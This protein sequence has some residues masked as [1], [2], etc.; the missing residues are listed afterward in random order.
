MAAYRLVRT[1]H[2]V[3][4]CARIAVLLGIAGSAQSALVTVD[5][6]AGGAGVLAL[7]TGEVQTTPGTNLLVNGQSLKAPARC[8]MQLDGPLT[9][10]RAEI[11]SKSGLFLGDYLP[12][13]AWIVLLQPEQLAVVKA[14][15]FVSW[16]GRF[17][18]DWKI[19]PEL[20]A[21][22]Y[23]SDA[24]RALQAQGLC[25]VVVVVFE[26]EGPD[27]VLAA[28]N[29]AGAQTLDANLC[30]PQWMIDAVL[31]PDA[32]R[33][34]ASLSSV[35]FIEDAPEGSLRNDSNRWILQSNVSGQT[36]VWARGIHGEGQIGGLIDDTP[37]ES[38]CMFD[39]SVAPG[40]VSHRKFVG[41]RNASGVAFHGTHTAGTMAGDNAPY[42]AYSNNDGI[43]YAAKL[44]FSN[45]NNV[46]QSPTTLQ[47]RLQ[48]AHNDG[49]RVHSNSWGDDGTTAYTTWCR[50]I[51]LF[52]W[53]NEDNLVVFAVS[54]LSSLKTPEN[55]INVLAVGATNDSPSQGN[56]C[57]G[58]AGPTAD[59]RRKPEIYAP[60]CGTQSAD[61]NSTCSVTSSSGTSMACP[62]ISGSGLLVRQY[63]TDG[64]YPSG[65]ATPGDAFTPS[66]ALIKAVLLNGSVDMTGVTGYPGN[67]EGWGRLL[68]DNALHFTGDLSK[69]RISDTRNADGLTTGQVV[70]QEIIC[71]SSGAPLRITL[72]WTG[73][74][75]SINAA[76]PVI[77]NLDLEVVAPGGVLYRGNVFSSGQS[78]TGGTAD[79][80][81]NVEQFLLSVPA[82]GAYTVRV[83]GTTVNQGPQ[84][85]ALAIT[86]DISDPC[87]APSILGQPD[88]VT[89]DEGA[90]AEFGV[91]ASGGDL[92]YIWR[93]NGFALSNDTRI[94]GANTATLVINPVTI[95]DAGDYD[96]IITGCDSVTSDPVAL[97]V[98][99]GNACP[100]D[101][102]GVEGLGVPD[103]FHFLSLWFANDPAADWDGENGL[104][105]PDIFTYLSDWF[106]GC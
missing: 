78:T 70:E 56:I 20:A 59:G 49:A 29:K 23:G 24:R 43:A 94:A 37:R 91:I 5:D 41:W 95:D 57:Y 45:L 68:L 85:Y 76:N 69:L 63:F 48:D 52:S 54:N 35:Q 61:S 4:V 67:R 36:P 92:S 8:V 75:A 74:A 96:V 80:K 16:I 72:V 105:V 17:E 42:G 103:I 81:N 15:P 25:Q 62:A 6:A 86:G 31:T 88:P 3:V 65:A 55:S 97:S 90:S 99:P 11:L 34:L 26:G 71:E 101:I 100:A 44:S 39:D 106:G 1:P 27:E 12:D 50:Q 98:T 13:N 82:T 73:P 14:I 89:A 53:E 21:R 83:R 32:A 28:L 38:H 51:D 30:G 66:G 60:G 9:A 40:S 33:A 22:P 7:R 64:F 87:N 18:S 104:G 79:L 46:V 19:D 47:P 93:R 84:G 2:G 102:D 58:G 77:N 10:E